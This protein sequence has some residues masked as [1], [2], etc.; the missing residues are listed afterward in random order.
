MGFGYV[1]GG[2]TTDGFHVH[3]GVNNFTY[4]SAYA[5]YP[6]CGTT[7]GTYCTCRVGDDY[8]GTAG[9]CNHSHS[10]AQARTQVYTVGTSAAALLEAPLY[11]AAKWGGYSDDALTKEEIAQ[12]EAETY[13][14]A[15]D[16]RELQRSLRDA[17]SHVAER[18]GSASAVAA[19]ST[20]VGNDTVIFQ[21]MLH[22][23]GWMGT[24]AE[25]TF[26]VT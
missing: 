4:T 5:E 10:R 8:D 6:G 25:V 11:Y 24:F 16:P 15:T 22:S 21:A 1:I 17:F 18:L 7:D 19:Y 3:S 23:D 13:Y 20:R 2:T 26:I 9:A 14:A 12:G